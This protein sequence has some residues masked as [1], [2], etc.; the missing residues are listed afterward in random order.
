MKINSRSFQ[1][2]VIDLSNLNLPVVLNLIER[3][4][5]GRYMSMDENTLYLLD[6]SEFSKAE[7][8]SI[9]IQR[10]GMMYKSLA[11]TNKLLNDFSEE[12]YSAH[13][14]TNLV[15]ESLGYK[16]KVPYV[17]GDRAIVPETGYTKKPASWLVLNHVQR[18]SFNVEEKLVHLTCHTGFSLDIYM[19]KKQFED[20]VCR[21]AHIYKIKS[22]LHNQIMLSY[23]YYYQRPSFKPKNIFDDKLMRLSYEY[24]D[25]T[26]NEVL[27]Q[28]LQTVVT[29]HLK[30]IL[31]DGNPFFDE[32]KEKISK[33]I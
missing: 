6:V 11:T 2:H 18:A 7:Y 12:L 15:A 14:V 24:P 4:L 17:V 16:Q 9:L 5:E 30:E 22:V 19:S 21:A 20:A 13:D 3:S 28:I 29:K 32:Y 23:N 8:R 27:Q 1:S 33:N 31:G 10:C 26:Y 25:Y